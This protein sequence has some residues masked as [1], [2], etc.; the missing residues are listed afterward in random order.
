MDMPNMPTL[1]NEPNLAAMRATNP[2][3]FSVQSRA[4]DSTYAPTSD[5]TGGGMFW[6]QLGNRLDEE[7]S[8]N[9]IYPHWR[10]VFLDQFAR[11]EPMLASAVYSMATRISGLNYSLSGPPRAKKM[12]MELLKRPGLGDTFIALRQKLIT[13]LHTSDNGAFLELW[14]AGNPASDAGS[15]PVLGF[16]HLDS[17][18]CWRSFDPEFPVWYTNPVNFQIRKLHRSRVVFTSDNPRA[19][20]LAR[21]IGFC[22][23]SRVLRMTRIFR[24]METFMSEKIGGRFTRALG[25]ISGVT[26]QQLR[27]ALQQNQDNADAKGYVVYNG[28]P[29][30]TSPN[31]EK[32]NEIKMFLQDLA[33]IPDGFTFRDDATI[34]AY[35]LAF[36]FGV[37]AREFWPA[38]ESGA[39]KADATVQNMKARGRGIGNDIEMVE[40]LVRAALPETVEFEFDFTDDDQDRTTAEIQKSQADTI[41][42]YFDMGALNA[43]QAQAMGIAKGHLD[44]DV[45]FMNSQPVDSDDNPDTPDDTGD[46]GTDNPDNALPAGE[47]GD[48]EDNGAAPAPQR[49][50]ALKMGVAIIHPS[51]GVITKTYT[52][53]RR[54]I[55]ELVRG[56]WSGELDRYDFLDSMDTQITKQFDAAWT[57]GARTVG[58]EPDERTNEEQATLDSAIADEIS[59]LGGFADAI[60]DNSRD[61]GGAL[62]PLLDRGDLWANAYAGIVTLAQTSSGADLK[63]KWF[64]GDTIDHCP[65]CSQYAGKVFRKSEWNEVGAKPQSRELACGGWKCDCYFEVTN[66]RKTRGKP[67]TLIGTKH[68]V[69]EALTHGAEV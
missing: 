44:A 55:K 12:A 25:S 3:K 15:R 46:Q 31:L 43:Q 24:D 6:I 33:S 32:G 20:E 42:L 27:A 63:M 36:C 40:E 9:P 60:A 11:S 41:K 67:P 38:T 64:Y 39:T 13:D 58:V 30:L 8:F 53:Y 48:L 45:L 68:L 2:D 56:Y 23:T 16:A 50:A 51:T 19:N 37:D 35:I 61:N 62:Q 18:Q 22:A 28:I 59:Y 69:I 26:P 21:G 65:D 34:Y 54:V 1:Q 66:E 47:R 7:P 4:E 10:D 14:R 5:V 17:R 57:E 49:A 29:F 52:S